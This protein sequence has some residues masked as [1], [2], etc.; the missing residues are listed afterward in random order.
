MTPIDWVMG[1]LL[2]MFIAALLV[3]VWVD[4]PTPRERAREQAKA[5]RAQESGEAYSRLERWDGLPGPRQPYDQGG[6]WQK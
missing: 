3:F 2:L 5:N 6:R 4:T 1:G